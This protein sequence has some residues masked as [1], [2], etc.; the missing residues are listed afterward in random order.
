MLLRELE[1][2]QKV[3][4]SRIGGNEKV[5]ELLQQRCEKMIEDA[6][7]SV[8]SL[9]THHE[10]KFTSIQTQF[11]ERDTRTEQA[12]AAVK[13]AVDAALSAQKEAV[14]EQNKSSAL[15]IAKSETATTKQIDQIGITIQNTTSNLNDKIDDVKARM[16]VIDGR[17]KGGME[18]TDNHRSNLAIAVSVI[19][20][21]ITVGVMLFASG[22]DSTPPSSNSV[23]TP[24]LIY[25]PAPA[26]APAPLAK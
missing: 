25:V 8:A 22:K 2:L 20:A 11:L 7:F 10:E 21:I 15:A 5:V 3:I 14:L 1:N 17:T 19:M 13:I 9:K 23:S 12:A 4:E 16:N 6:R 26:V 18:T 24:Q